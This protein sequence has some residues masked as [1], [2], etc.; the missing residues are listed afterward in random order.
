[1]V[2]TGL[3]VFMSMTTVPVKA[4]TLYV[5]GVGPGNYTQIQDA[6]DNASNGDTVYVYNGW[7][8]ENVL[9]NKKINL[10]G[11]SVANTVIRCSSGHGIK[12]A[13]NWVNISEFIVDGVAPGAC[14]ARAGIHNKAHDDVIIKN[15]EIKN[16]CNGIYFKHD[17]ELGDTVERVIIEN[18]NIHHNGNASCEGSFHGI[19]MR[20]V[21]NSIIRNNSIHD[22]IAHVDPNPGCEDGGNGLFL[23]KGNHNNIT[24]NKFYNNTKGGLFIKMKPKYWNI[25]YNHLWGNGQGGIILRCKLC[26]HNIIEH[27]NASDNYGSGIFIGGN[28]NTIRYNIICNNKD[29]GPYYQDSVGGHGYGINIGRNDGSCDNEL[30][31]NTVCG[32]NYMDIYVV[33]GVTG[34]TGDDNTCNTTN[35]YNDNGTTG[36]TWNCPGKM[37]LTITEKYEEWIVTEET[38][39]V[40]YIIKNLEHSTAVESTTGIYIDGS[41]AKTDPVGV[42][43]PNE[44]YIRTV[45]P[46]TM[47]GENDTIKVCADY[48]DAISETNED[49]NCLENVFESCIEYNIPLLEGWNLISIPL[50][51]SDTNIDSVLKDIAGQW[52]IIR[53]YNATDTNDHWET[54]ATF[55]PNGLN[56]LSNID[57]KMAIWINITDV[58]DGYLTVTGTSASSTSIPLY[59]GWNFVGYPTLNDTVAI[60]E[61]L[62][63]TG[64]DK[65]EGFDKDALPYYLKI[66]SDDYVMKP[67]E[68]Y[69]IHVPADTTWIVD[70]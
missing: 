20:Y 39:N 61:A 7:Y 10:I 12:I 36:C 44:S 27:N 21:Y 49:N 54:N 67:G 3:F 14:G 57:R 42:I 1:M 50:K 63:G 59:K 43:G 60:A 26:D 28:S 15:L 11:E 41:L 9:V 23:Y 70:W 47:T 13:A 29:D 25:S 62:S 58:G 37:D 68:G 46:F 35:N 33:S 56:D 40:I 64:Y 6:I 16:F 18:C 38:Y 52:D 8:N 31:N 2:F 53:Y 5:G 45:G 69:W 32:N 51:Q 19:T 4:D 55:K 22:Q 66:L 48:E 65:V 17:P 30:Y 24:G 34:N